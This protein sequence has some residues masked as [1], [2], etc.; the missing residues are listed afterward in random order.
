MY[1]LKYILKLVFQMNKDYKTVHSIWLSMIM[2]LSMILKMMSSTFAD[3][4]LLTFA[5]HFQ[6]Y[7]NK[8][9]LFNHCKTKTI[10][11]GSIMITILFEK[12]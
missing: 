9:L 3:I 1:R 10:L 5:I 6:V 12:I 4:S 11:S 2:G 8:K 7:N